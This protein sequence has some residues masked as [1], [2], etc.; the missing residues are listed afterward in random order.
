MAEEER[1]WCT[2]RAIPSSAIP[3][4][5]RRRLWVME[6]VEKAV[7]ASGLPFFH[8][9]LPI[10]MLRAVRQPF[11]SD[12]IE[13]VSA[14]SSV[15]GEK[16]NPFL[17]SVGFGV[18][19]LF[20]LCFVG[21]FSRRWTHVYGKLVGIFVGRGRRRR[22]SRGYGTRLVLFVCDT[23]FLLLQFAPPLTA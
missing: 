23:P 20:S 17:V 2:G 16:Q 4:L 15:G 5:C 7:A 9:Y 22:T 21:K 3:S 18:V 6:T 10:C 8:Q 19:S 14:K 12:K 13:Q 11:D 1:R